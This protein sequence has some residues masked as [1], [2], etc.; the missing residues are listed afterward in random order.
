MFFLFTIVYIVSQY[1]ITYGI[2]LLEVRYL[3]KKINLRS[4][5]MGDLNARSNVK[6]FSCSFSEIVYL[7]EIKKLLPKFNHILH[8]PNLRVY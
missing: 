4:E 7:F 8:I 1:K 2:N 3:I 5:N 6:P